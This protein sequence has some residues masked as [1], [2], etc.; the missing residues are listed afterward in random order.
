MRI[1]EG[2]QAQIEPTSSFDLVI[3]ILW[4]RLGTPL[5]GPDGR[6][7][8]SGT[9]YEIDSALQSWSDQGSPEVMVYHNESPVQLRRTPKEERE[10]AY[11]QLEDLEEFLE[12]RSIDRKSGTIKGALTKY[13]NL[14]QF[15]MLLERHL[16]RFLEKRLGAETTTDPMAPS[17]SRTWKKGSP[18]R[19]LEVFEFEHESIFFGRTKAIGEVLDQLRRQAQRV[20]EFR[21]CNAPS[22]PIGLPRVKEIPDGSVTPVAFLLVSA[23]SGVGK[24]SL[25]RAGVL[26]LLTKRGVVE[27][28]DFWRRA[29]IRP[30]DSTGDLFDGLVQA[31]VR[32]EALPELLTTGDPVVQ[33][34]SRLRQTPVGMDMLISQALS[35]VEDGVLKDDQESLRRFAEESHREGRS[36]DEE[37][38][39]QSLRNLQR[40]VGRL[41]LVV[42]QFEEVFTI[43]KIVEATE[44]RTGFVSALAT[45]ARSGKVWVV[46]TLRSDFFPRCAELPELMALKQ[47]DGHYDLQPPT[48][49]EIGE[50]IRKSAAAAGLRYERI[51]QAG[52]DM[53]LDEALRDAMIDNPASLPLLEFCLEELYK[54]RSGDGVLTFAAYDE[55]GRL[56]GSLEKRAEAMFSSIGASPQAAFDHVMRGVTTVGL[57]NEATF[58]RRW[59]DY[60][61]LT[62]SP[63]AKEF[64]DKFIAPNAR[65][66]V[67]D[68]TD[69]GR[70][71]VSVAHEALLTAWQRLRVWLLANRES[72]QARAQISAVA[73]HWKEANE[74][75]KNGYLIHE[76]L[77]LEKAKEA[78]K[79]GYLEPNEVKFIEACEAAVE[80]RKLKESRRRKTV[81]TTISAAL[82]A[83]LVF[84]AISLWQAYKAEDSAKREKIARSKAEQSARAAEFLARERERSAEAANRARSEADG[85]INFMLSDLKGKLAPLGGLSLLADVAKRVSAYFQNLPKDEIS[86]PRLLEQRSAFD[87][88]GD[89]FASLGDYED[90]V[91]SYQESLK[92]GEALVGVIPDN[93]GF[94]RDTLS[95]QVKIG[96]VFVRQARPRE[97]LHEYQEALQILETLL[98]RDAKN[99]DFRGDL[100]VTYQK[101]GDV[102]GALGDSRGALENHQKSVEIARQL[103]TEDP[104]NSVW[105][106]DLEIGLNSIAGVFRY[107]GNSDQSLKYYQEAVEI[108]ERLAAQDPKNLNLQRDLILCRYWT[109]LALASSS[110]VHSRENGKTSLEK[111]LDMAKS[112]LGG[113]RETWINEIGK[114]LQNVNP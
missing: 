80:N 114:A 21:S 97:A 113:D 2:F 41:V 25:I 33:L 47:V 104:N 58:S 85:L 96:D 92:L 75:D 3:C 98:A 49:E 37:F 20:D 89:V 99:D 78:S 94:Q 6:A 73:T 1:N 84:A 90:A 31:L 28:V 5:T 4:S 26:P 7:Y 9:E 79:L 86:L 39:D 100:C 16:R 112:Y 38:Y 107:Q 66:F 27:G 13:E 88:V 56:E 63:G 11:R 72:L 109:G 45:L 76:G 91:S 22:T 81:L 110:D 70:A 65:L 87:T 93:A 8:K 30:S 74:Q 68:R 108:A 18:F 42:D 111:A 46:L 24:S 52:N 77:Q 106:R 50:I 71:V 54:R 36:L 44:T 19:G 10:K 102:L 83:A 59:A 105:L 101:I 67:A 61:Q 32:D 51:V 103:L 62:D 69:D 82:V 34:A 64:V 57:E 23:V 29:V 53:S 55:L 40:K 95:T 17:S 43:P 12:T 48:K 35:R 15:E 60:G 14:G